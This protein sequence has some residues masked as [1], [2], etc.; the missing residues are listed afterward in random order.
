VVTQRGVVLQR[1]ALGRRQVLMATVPLRRGFTF[2]DHLGDLPVLVLAAVALAA[3]WVRQR[4]RSGY[5]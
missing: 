1:S 2:Y 5:S 3:G 4:R